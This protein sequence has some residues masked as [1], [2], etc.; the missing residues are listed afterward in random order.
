MFQLVMSKKNLFN[1]HYQCG[2]VFI[3]LLMYPTKS[4]ATKATSIF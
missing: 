4:H 3:F 1:I 2:V